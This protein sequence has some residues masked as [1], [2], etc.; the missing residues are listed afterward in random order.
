MS[1]DLRGLVFVGSG[2]SSKTARGIRR[3]AAMPNYNGE[4]RT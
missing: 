4:T 1:I 3:R 2:D